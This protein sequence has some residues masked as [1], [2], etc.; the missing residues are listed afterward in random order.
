M[1]L[2]INESRVRNQIR[3]ER[4]QG[5]GATIA[6]GIMEKGRDVRREG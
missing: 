5:T 2:T 6:R 1:I 3:G 4:E